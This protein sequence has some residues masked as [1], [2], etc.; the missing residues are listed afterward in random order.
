MKLARR[1]AG[2]DA[3]LRAGNKA[4]S[5]RRTL[6]ALAQTGRWLERAD[7]SEALY[8]K[9]ELCFSSDEDDSEDSSKTRSPRAQRLD[10]R[11]QMISE[12]RRHLESGML[13]AETAS[14]VRTHILRIEKIEHISLMS[15]K[16][17]PNTSEMKKKKRRDS[18]DYVEVLTSEE[19]KTLLHNMFHD[20]DG[21]SNGFIDPAEIMDV[22][23]ETG[24][25]M[26][27]MDVTMVVNRMDTVQKDGVLEFDEFERA[28]AGRAPKM[29]EFV[30][31]IEAIHKEV[32]ADEV[33]YEHEKEQRKHDER[34]KKV[35][36]ER[37]KAPSDFLMSMVATRALSGN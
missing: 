31:K 12:L 4:T 23:A 35:D 14:Q 5:M 29:A 11:E 32:Q 19:R 7:E 18:E 1:Q 2:K 22:L 15:I 26:G 28:M 10:K 8:G 3:F 17:T 21:G 30:K 34:K 9:R 27:L 36:A 33:Q 37:S 13:D 20:I 16:M 6:D 24:L 25:E